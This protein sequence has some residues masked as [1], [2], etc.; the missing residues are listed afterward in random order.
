M[1]IDTDA[2]RHGIVTPAGLMNSN[3]YLSVAIGY[4]LTHRPRWPTH[5]DVGKTLV[6]SS[7]I[8]RW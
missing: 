3:H 6:S 4:L 5:A 2:D 7:M 1:L 8:D